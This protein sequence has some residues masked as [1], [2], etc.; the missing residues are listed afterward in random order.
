M[1]K[2]FAIFLVALC[3]IAK[4]SIFSASLVLALFISSSPV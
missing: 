2:L 3:I 1:F 4:V